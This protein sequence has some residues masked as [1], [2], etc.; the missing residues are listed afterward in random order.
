M[1]TKQQQK[2][3]LVFADHGSIW[4]MTFGTPAGQEWIADHM[5][6]H[7]QRLGNAIAIEFRYVADIIVGAQGDGLT[8]SN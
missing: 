5:P 7:A 8:V 6:D 2:P 1:T 3:D 4:L